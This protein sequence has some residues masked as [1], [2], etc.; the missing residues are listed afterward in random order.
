VHKFGIAKLCKNLFELLAGY[1]LKLS[2]PKA[3]YFGLLRSI[4][5]FKA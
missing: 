2:S 4:G 1:C 3:N 5:A